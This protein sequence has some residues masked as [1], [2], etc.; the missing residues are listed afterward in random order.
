[1]WIGVGEDDANKGAEVMK[2]GKALDG[3]GMCCS[4]GAAISTPV[5]DL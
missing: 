2:E 4:G 1:M 3:K 5:L